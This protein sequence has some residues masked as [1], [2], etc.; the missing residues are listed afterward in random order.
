MRPRDLDE[1]VGQDAVIGPG[2]VLRRVI[3]AGQAPSLI[4]YGPPGTGKTTLAVLIAA[5]TGSDFERLSA[6]NAGVADIRKVVERARERQRVGRSTV[7]FIDEIH[8]FNK[9]QQDAI[10][11]HVESGLIHLLGATTENPS[12]EVNAAL[13]SR[14]RGVRLEALDAEALARVVDRALGDAERGLAGVSLSEEAFDALIAG[15]GGDARIALNALEVAAASASGAV[16]RDDVVGALASRT[17][18]YDKGG[19]QHYWLVSALIKSMRDSDPDAAIYWLAR[20]LEAGE[21]PM[22]I[23]RRMVILAAEDVGLA[24]PQALPLAVAAQQATHAIGMPEAYL[25]LAECALYL[26]CADKSNSAYRAYNAARADVDATLHEPVPLHLRNAVTALGRSLG[27]GAGYEYA[28]DASAAITAQEHL[29][30]RLRGRH[31][32]E[33]TD[34]GGERDIGQRLA[35][36][37]NQIE[38]RRLT[39]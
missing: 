30:E 14:S 33:P 31:Y 36:V 35:S 29:P 24:D 10:L 12:F 9:G 8:R 5:R 2:T 13:L 4:F 18:L 20:M 39:N 38:A 7:L 15:C 21:D 22:F 3:D 28:H 1:V 25:P 37:R 17:L 23:A 34:N 19:D 6:V 27:F 16:S 32:Y 11:P 26:A